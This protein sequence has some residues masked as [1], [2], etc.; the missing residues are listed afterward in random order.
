MSRTGGHSEERAPLEPASVVLSV[1]AENNDTGE[2]LSHRKPLTP[3]AR[4]ARRQCPSLQ[5]PSSTIV[6]AVFCLLCLLVAANT[7][8][9]R[10]VI[11]WMTWLQQ[12]EAQGRVLFVL[13]YTTCL[14]LLLPASLLAVLAGMFSPQALD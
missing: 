10:Y 1:T 3:L 12:H 11:V 7:W 13:G 4:H 5:W 9:H 6:A 14:L 8:S 2:L